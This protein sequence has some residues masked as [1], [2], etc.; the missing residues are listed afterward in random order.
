VQSKRRCGGKSGSGRQFLRLYT[1]VK[2]SK[3][4]HGL[5]LKARA[6]L[7][8]IIDRFTGVNNGMIGLGAR[9]AR[10]ELG[11]SHGSVCAAM[12]ELDES[13][14]TPNC[15]YWTTK[16]RHSIGTA[17]NFIDTSGLFL[18]SVR[19]AYH[20]LTLFLAPSQACRHK[21]LRAGAWRDASG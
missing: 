5:S 1:N 19:E 14:Q 16:K 15:R 2:R 18:L 8:E 4:Y 12:H 13:M 9:E 6:L 3:A 11:I 17:R 10:H 21:L 7:F 20:G